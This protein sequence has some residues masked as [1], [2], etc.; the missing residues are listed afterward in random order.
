MP[1]KDPNEWIRVKDKDLN[2]HVTI[3]RVSLPHGNYQELKQDA[4]GVDGEPLAPEFL[5]DA[6]AA[7][8]APAKSK[9]S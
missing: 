4:V 8:S 5:D 2:R 7:Q 3:R 9:E 1:E 6:D